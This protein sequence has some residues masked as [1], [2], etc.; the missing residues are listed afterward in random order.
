MEYIAIDELN[1][2]SFHDAEIQK[3]DFCFGN[4]KWQVTAANAT[5]QNTQN[6][7]QKDMCIDEAEIIFEDVQ[8]EKIVFSA[9]KVFDSN[10]NLIQSVEEKIADSDEYIDILE[11]TVSGFC[12][13]YSMENLLKLD[14]KKYSVCFNIDGSVGNYYLTLLFSKSIVQWNKYR[15]IAWY[16]DEKWKKK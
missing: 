4:M 6:S 10:N 3:I 12:Y 16:E 14:D 2:F 8:V 13:I 1:H 11:N 9:Y 5:I 15:G 7:L